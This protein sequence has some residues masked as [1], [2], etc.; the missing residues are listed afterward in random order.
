METKIRLLDDTTINQIAAGEVIENASSVVKELVENSLD[1]SATEITVEIKAG[2]RQL[3]RIIDNGIGMSPDDAIL[4]LERHATSK[5]RAV[6]D[7][8]SITTMGFRGEA[9]PSIASISKFTL[10]TRPKNQDTTGT[11]VLVEGGKIKKTCEVMRAPG[12]TIE[13]KNLFYNLPVRQKFQR[14]VSYDAGEIHKI[15]SSIALGNPHVKFNL[16]SQEKNILSIPAWNGNNI[17]DGIGDRIKTLLG[18]GLYR[19]IESFDYK[20][21]PYHFFGY[22][23]TPDYTRHNR[24]GQYLYING[25]PIFSCTNKV[26]IALQTPGR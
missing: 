19:N 9:I 16:I 8:H 14:S 12:T 21:A 4:C 10:L 13:I 23:G 22:L 26:S 3:I 7:V 5:I 17:L 6:E 1:A 20:D 15:I 24:T 25:R 2:G 11:M 18:E